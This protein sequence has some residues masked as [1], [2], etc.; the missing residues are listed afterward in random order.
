MYALLNVKTNKFYRGENKYGNCYE[1]DLFIDA[2][3]FKEIKDA[4]YRNTLLNLISLLHTNI[5]FYFLVEL[6]SQPFDW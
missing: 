1:V 4:Y 3:T 5:S 6:E 2:Y